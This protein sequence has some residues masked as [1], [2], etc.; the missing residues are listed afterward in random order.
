MRYCPAS[1][2]TWVYP[3]KSP[4]SLAATC[5]LPS[6]MKVLL[7]LRLS[8]SL[9]TVGGEGGEPG[10]GV[11]VGVLV[12]ATSTSMVNWRAYSPTVSPCEGGLVDVLMACV[13][14]SSGV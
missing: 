10:A 3:A 6:S 14:W 7:G 5:R 13:C 2:G 12:M 11:C 1:T 4:S 9:P 8:T